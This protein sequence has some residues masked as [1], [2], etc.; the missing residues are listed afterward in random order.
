M[1]ENPFFLLNCALNLKLLIGN[2]F[3]GLHS[4]L[5]PNFVTL[6]LL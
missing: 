4:L 5:V 6:A 3:V 2:R 1:Y